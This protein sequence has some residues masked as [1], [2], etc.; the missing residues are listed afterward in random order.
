MD[1]SM[2]AQIAHK[3]ESSADAV[4]AIRNRGAV[5]RASAAG[6]AARLGM[7]PTAPLGEQLAARGVLSMA[8][9]AWLDGAPE[10]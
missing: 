1:R 6:L 7:D 10:G 4:R 3:L 9:G 5:G 8:E 2:D